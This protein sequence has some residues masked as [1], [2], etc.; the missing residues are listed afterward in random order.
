MPPMNMAGFGGPESGTNLL[1][2][3]IN[4]AFGFVG[5]LMILI[6]WVKVIAYGSHLAT[7]LLDVVG[8]GANM[9]GFGIATAAPYIVLAPIV[10]LV[11]KELAGVKSLKS[12]AYFAAAVAAGALIAFL[13]QGYFVAVIAK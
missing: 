10:G 13:T 7:Q 2:I 5:T 4:T 9:G 6:G 12:F 11:V 1:S 8:Y 3:L